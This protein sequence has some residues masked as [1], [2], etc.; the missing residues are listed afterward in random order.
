MLQP[1]SV[2][3]QKAYRRVDLGSQYN[4]WT[5]VPG[6]KWRHPEW[7]ASSIDSAPQHPVVDV[8]FEDAEALAKWAGKELPMEVRW[9]FAA[10]G[11]LEGVPYAW[12]NEFAP[13]GKQMADTR[14]GEFPWENLISPIW[15]D[16]RFAMP[17]GVRDAW[18]RPHR[19]PHPAG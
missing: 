16:L 7:P 17:G 6:A 11:G 8:A 1:A 10:R 13:S 12:G 14:Q 18:R 15:I 5:Y 4:R 2:V 9:K 3:F 19:P